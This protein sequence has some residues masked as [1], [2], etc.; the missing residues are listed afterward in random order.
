MQEGGGVGAGAWGQPRPRGP[1]AAVCPS[2]QQPKRDWLQWRAR[3]EP[4]GSWTVLVWLESP[5]RTE[6]QQERR[7]HTFVRRR[8]SSG[9]RDQI[10]GIDTNL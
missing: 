5:L 8:C 3:A 4:Y 1:L 6:T 10:Q 7:N 2:G 9:P